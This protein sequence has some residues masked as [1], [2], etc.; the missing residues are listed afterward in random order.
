MTPR[1]FAVVAD[2]YKNR[3]EYESEQKRQEIY[4]SALLI[5]RFVWAKRAPSYDKVFGGGAKAEMTD[6][7]MLK[8]AESLNAMFGG[9]DERGGK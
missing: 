7:Q 2:A 9:L 8:T 3:M 1:E 5:S 6:E 4:A